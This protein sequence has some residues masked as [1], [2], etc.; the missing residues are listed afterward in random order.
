[1]CSYRFIWPKP[2]TLGAYLGEKRLENG[3]NVDQKTKIVRNRK[4]CLKLK[5]HPDWPKMPL[6]LIYAHLDDSKVCSYRFIWPK[7]GT[8]GAY[9]GGKRPENGRTATGF[10]LARPDFN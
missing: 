3:R 5:T 8:L 6:S 4:L 7:P 1:V 2:G 10:G 9:L